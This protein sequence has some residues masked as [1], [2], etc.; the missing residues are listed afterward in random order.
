MF[1]LE[2]HSISVINWY[3]AGARSFVKS[4][5]SPTEDKKVK[6]ANPRATSSARRVSRIKKRLSTAQKGSAIQN[7]N[8]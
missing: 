5:Q 7:N 4:I 8:K 2:A 1:Q 3:C 6:R